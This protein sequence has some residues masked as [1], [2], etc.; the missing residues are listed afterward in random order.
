MNNKAWEIA[1]EEKGHDKERCCLDWIMEHRK[2]INDTIFKMVK[3][4]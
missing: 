4:K 1:R 2:D 3:S